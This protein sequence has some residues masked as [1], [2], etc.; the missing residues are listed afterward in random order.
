MG[1]MAIPK[2]VRGI[3]GP[4]MDNAILDSRTN[5]TEEINAELAGQLLM[6]RIFTNTRI[7][8][9]IFGGDENSIAGD[10]HELA[11]PL[12]CK[13]HVNHYIDSH[14]KIDLTR[15]EGI[16]DLRELKEDQYG[17]VLSYRV[18]GRRHAV[19]KFVGDMALWEIREV[20]RQFNKRK[21]AAG[22][23]E[24]FADS[25]IEQ[26]EAAGAGEDTTIAA[27]IAEPVG[28]S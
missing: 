10:V 1:M 15:E 20:A 28:V 8:I 26:M 12:F 5:D 6:E 9:Q 27:A 25:I 18:K 14:L 11:V 16:G 17:R 22:K 19:I 24:A 4:M 2:D 23:R 13:Y 3:L 7:R 21:N